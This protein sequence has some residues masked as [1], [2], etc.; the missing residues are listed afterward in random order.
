MSSIQNAQNAA[1]E[2]TRAAVETTSGLAQAGS[3]AIWVNVIN[4]VKDSM[5]DITTS[6]ITYLPKLAGALVLYIVGRIVITAVT[7]L[8]KRG[9]NMIHFDTW[10]T[11]V[12]VTEMIQRAN[13]TATA[14]GVVAKVVYYALMLVLIK[15]LLDVIGFQAGA[16][17]FNQLIAAIPAYLGAAVIVGIAVV[18]G[19]VAHDIIQNATAASGL[20]GGSIMARV[21]NYAIVFIGSIMALRQL[22]LDTSII[23]DN[24]TVIVAGVV[25]MAA[26]ALGLGGRTAAENLIGGYYARNM[27]KAGDRVTIGSV[28][29]TVDSVSSTMVNINTGSGIESIPAGQVMAN[30]VKKG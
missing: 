25:A 6:A 1:A 30:T 8:V 16:D 19:K 12:G 2:T 20:T 27:L 22:K 24:L 3:D 26:I 14:S 15:L 10:M 13:T 21:A 29:G 23:T 11:K 18:V 28:S 5:Y 7:S 17:A 4:P 9:L